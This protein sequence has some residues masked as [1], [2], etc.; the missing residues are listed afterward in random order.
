MRRTEKATTHAQESLIARADAAAAIA[1]VEAC[2]A[3]A[4]ARE[5]EIDA[6][7]AR[8]ALK[9]FS[10]HPPG[11]PCR[12]IRDTTSASHQEASDVMHPSN[13]A[14]L[15]K[16]REHALVARLE[17]ALIDKLD[18]RASC[19][20]D[21]SRSQVL[22]RVFRAAP[23]AGI[24]AHLC[25]TRE[26]F[27]H[28]LS[29]LGLPQSITA[30][31]Q[32]TQ[33]SGVALLGAPAEVRTERN[34]L[35]VISDASIERPVIDALFDK[36]AESPQ[37]AMRVG[38]RADADDRVVDIDALYSNIM[39]SA[40]QATNRRASTATNRCRASCGPVTRDL[41]GPYNY[42]HPRRGQVATTRTA[43]RTVGM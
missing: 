33:P 15:I 41:H 37:H 16:S 26:E 10:S 18:Q 36:Y 38:L 34:Q 19:D 1:R 3:A 23:A 6:A 14:D 11:V 2:Q 20:S 7:A 17:Q 22:R 43:G 21:S 42:T 8:L 27:H 40:S 5:L 24:A 12:P 31:Q 25:A 30:V 39:R 32:Y 29:R 13:T 28:G 9:D 35:A 4:A